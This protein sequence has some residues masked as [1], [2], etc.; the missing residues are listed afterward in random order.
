[1]GGSGGWNDRRRAPR[2]PSRWAFAAAALLACT[3]L[4]TTI[5][6]TATAAEPSPSPSGDNTAEVMKAIAQY[7]Q[8]FAEADCDAFFEV[9]T[10]GFRNYLAIPDCET[11][12]NRA[13]GRSEIMD[14]MEFTPISIGGTGRATIAALVHVK[15]DSLIDQNFE[16]VPS[17]VPVEFDYRFHLVHLGGAWK[18][19]DVHDL[20]GG[21]T[22]G[23]VS[24]E[25]Q[26][27]VDR[28]MV[29]WQSA[30]STGDCDALM[31]STTAGYRETMKWPDCAT[32]QQYIADQNAYCP[33]DVHQEDIRFHDSLDVHNTEIELDVVEVCTLDTDEAGN[34]LDPPYQSGAPYR[35]HLVDVDGTWLIAEGD[36]QAAAEDDAD[37][38]NERAALET[39]GAY[40]QAWSDADCV[41]YASTTTE[42][43]RDSYGLS[44]CAAFGPAAR[45]WSAGVANFAF[46]ATD[47]ERPSA[48]R[49]EIKSHETFDSLTDADGQP[50]DAPVLI[51]EYWVYTI[52]LVQGEWVISDIVMLV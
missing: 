10:A 41:A 31:A 4:L 8:A 20:T 52:D 23:L 21:R 5:P 49:F 28:L 45:E 24:A 43:L 51:D 16:R 17:P 34:P 7:D 30:Y 18:I 44:G 48:T 32:F 22:Q 14:P 19:Q 47:I 39:M 33:M 42:G 29:D 13:H 12:V 3:G 9:T 38:T 1:M 40:N 25:E 46:T 15:F 11:F 2:H 35:Y 26:Q 37:N 27:A 6:A 36:D 50:L